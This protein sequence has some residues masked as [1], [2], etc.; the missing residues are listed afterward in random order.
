M[1]IYGGVDLYLPAFLTL[2]IGEVLSFTPRPLYSREQKETNG[3]KQ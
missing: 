3:S 2:Q 1:K